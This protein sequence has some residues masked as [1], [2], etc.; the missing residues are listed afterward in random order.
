MQ[1]IKES[2]VPI[3]LQLV[4]G[5]GDKTRHSSRFPFFSRLPSASNRET[6][7]FSR[8]DLE[9]FSLNARA[10][11]LAETEALAGWDIIDSRAASRV[12]VGNRAKEE[13]KRGNGLISFAAG[14]WYPR[15]I[16]PTVFWA[17]AEATRGRPRNSRRQS[18]RCETRLRVAF[19]ME[20]QLKE[21]VNGA[22]HF[23]PGGLIVRAGQ[24]PAAPFR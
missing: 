1:T 8:D 19:L 12:T 16:L 20:F 11:P 17:E 9:A 15:E 7:T 24:K 6:F 4:P 13:R 22:S 14:Y 23:V 3:Y 18:R 2:V 10:A 5:I 21:N